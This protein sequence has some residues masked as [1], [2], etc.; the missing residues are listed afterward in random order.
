M[1]EEHGEVERKK[2]PHQTE[3][4]L[5]FIVPFLIYVTLEE[6]TLC[7]VTRF[8]SL[9]IKGG[10]CE[11]GPELGTYCPCKMCSKLKFMQKIHKK[12]NIKCLNKNRLNVTD[13]SGLD[14][15]LFLTRSFLS[16]HYL[17]Q[18]FCDWASSL[19]RDMATFQPPR[20]GQG[21]SANTAP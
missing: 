20:P 11:A 21:G 18:T 13:F 12:Q 6:A 14:I 17:P 3:H 15:A 7:S 5:E 16:K 19:R 2:K 8:P 1:K 10:R 4:T 9:K